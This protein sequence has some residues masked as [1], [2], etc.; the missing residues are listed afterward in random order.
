MNAALR[1]NQS[2]QVHYLDTLKGCGRRLEESISKTFF[3]IL[4]MVVRKLHCS[5]NTEAEVTLFI[6]ALKWRFS[7]RDHG[8]LSLLQVFETLHKSEKLRLHWGKL[9]QTDF[10]DAA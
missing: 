6:N 3:T 8:S 2:K 5:S 7:A 10:E 1:D 4:S 9:I